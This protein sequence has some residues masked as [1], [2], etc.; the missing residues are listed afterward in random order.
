MP[1][2]VLDSSLALERVPETGRKRPTLNTAV[3]TRLSLRPDSFALVASKVEFRSLPN[4]GLRR[5]VTN[6]AFA[7]TGQP[8]SLP[9]RTAVGMNAMG[10]HEPDRYPARTAGCLRNTSSGSHAEPC[11]DNRAAGVD[12][13]QA[14]ITIASSNRRKKRSPIR[15]RSYFLRSRA[16]SG[17]LNSRLQHRRGISTTRTPSGS[18]P[19]RPVR[20]PP[21]GGLSL[22]SLP[23]LMLVSYS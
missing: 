16:T 9:R 1:G 14:L 3:R 21:R 11:T 20:L 5:F 22:L 2:S 13:C 8:S 23:A 18:F 4:T 12:L 15:R 6:C 7:G 17:P 19:R 10:S